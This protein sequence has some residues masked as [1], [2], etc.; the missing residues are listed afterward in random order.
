M[1]EHLFYGCAAIDNNIADPFAP[2][3]VGLAGDSRQRLCPAHPTCAHHALDAQCHRRLDGRDVVET[4]RQLVIHLGE[5][6]DV[7][8][9]DHIV[10]KPPENLTF[11]LTGRAIDERMQ[12]RFQYMP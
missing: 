11:T 5:Q 9:N 6:R 10:A 7:M 1:F 12:N 2:A 4:E 8:H 3:V